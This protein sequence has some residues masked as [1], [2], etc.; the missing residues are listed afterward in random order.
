MLPPRGLVDRYSTFRR[1]LPNL[2]DVIDQDEAEGFSKRLHQS[3][4]EHCFMSQ[5]TNLNRGISSVW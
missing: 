2:Y 5:K 4:M 1:H 3:A